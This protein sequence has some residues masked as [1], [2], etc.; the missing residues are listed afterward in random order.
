[1]K[2]LTS[3]GAT[4]E[5]SVVGRATP[6]AR[7]EVSKEWG[8]V[9]DGSDQWGRD[10]SGGAYCGRGCTRNSDDNGGIVVERVGKANSGGKLSGSID[11]SGCGR[12]NWCW[13]RNLLSSN[14]VD[15]SSRGRNLQSLSCLN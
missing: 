14:V 5:M 10:W 11:S 6:S 2:T 1:M 15:D 8:N 12:G 9:T 4:G 13:Y 7:V 3:R